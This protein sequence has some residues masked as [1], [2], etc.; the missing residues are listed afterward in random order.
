MCCLIGFRSLH[1][2]KSMGLDQ[3]NS[4]GE[5]CGPHTAYLATTAV[6]YLHW[7]VVNPV[8]TGRHKGESPRFSFPCSRNLSYWEFH[9]KLVFLNF[10][11]N[12]ADGAYIPRAQRQRIFWRGVGFLWAIFEQ[13]SNCADL[14]PNTLKMKSIRE[15]TFFSFFFG[16]GGGGVKPC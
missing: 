15:I 7:S 11:F 3:Y 12:S 2:S 5:N 10:M 16:G 1:P 14:W 9:A 6:P 8:Q 4:L 13:G